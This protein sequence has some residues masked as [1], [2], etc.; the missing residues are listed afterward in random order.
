MGCDR[1]PGP[2]TMPDT[3]IRARSRPAHT[4]RLAA[5]LRISLAVLPAQPVPTGADPK[6]VSTRVGGPQ[7]ART[8]GGGY[9]TRAPEVDFWQNGVSPAKKSGNSSILWPG[10]SYDANSPVASFA[11]G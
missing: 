8:V 9:P 4:P 3:E 11:V 10:L 6:A 7:P 2:Q 1:L 5:A